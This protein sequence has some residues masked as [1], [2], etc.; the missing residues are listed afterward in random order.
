MALCAHCQNK[1]APILRRKS[2][3]PHISWELQLQC[4]LKQLP[5]CSRPL[6]PCHS[7][8]Y[9][10]GRLPGLRMWNLQRHPHIFQDVMFRLVTA[11]VAINDQARRALDERAPQRI[12]AGYHQR[13]R[14]HNSRTA[15]FAQFFARIHSVFLHHIHTIV[16]T[17]FAKLFHIRRPIPC[18]SS[19]FCSA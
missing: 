17:I 14:L 7:S 5:H 1:I 3:A 4:H 8:T 11:P 13:H 15:P 10:P 19:L 2:D 16:G 18:L 6:N 9:L 12:H